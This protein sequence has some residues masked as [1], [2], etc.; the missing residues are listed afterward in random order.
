M[1][2][3]IER[4]NTYYALYY[5]GQKQ[6]RVS[7]K[8]HVRPTA[9]D[10][11]MTK[12]QLRKLAQQTA[13]SMELGAR[14][15]VSQRQA[16]EAVRAHLTQRKLPS[17][18][19]YFE[20][21]KKRCEEKGL[22]Y[23]STALKTFLSL[24]PQCADLPL[25]GVTRAM[26]ENYVEKAL[27]EVSGSTVD[28]RLADLSAC[29]NHAIKE[30]LIDRNPFRGVRVPKWEMTAHER[31]PFTREDLRRIFSTFGGEWPDMVAVCLLLG[32]QRL[33]DIATMRWSQIDLTAG[34]VKL[35]TKKTKRPMLKPIILPL[36]RI[37]ERRRTAIGES[38]EHVFPYAM[39]RV[40][41]AGG[42]TNKLSIEFGDLCRAA[43]ISVKMESPSEGKTKVHKLTDKTFHSLRTTATTFLLDAG[44][45]AELV[46]YIV[47]HDDK[48]I[49][50]RHYLKPSPEHEAKYI[51]ALA[52]VL[53]VPQH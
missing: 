37:F 5:I 30:E 24:M 45:P 10:G 14:G 3:L 44:T 52:A 29:F 28:R 46:R 34:L 53:G 39:A 4:G 19:I 13:D 6:V 35:Q 33:G 25:D 48:E 22:K 12:T 40:M 15:I 31:Q 20:Q 16:L 26:A 38:S 2:G 41:C 43:G 36:K 23:A 32:G 50:R 8:V 11:Q 17:V 18:R 27:D 49:E 7:T 21:Y 42:K 47:G 51:D 1:A 9:K